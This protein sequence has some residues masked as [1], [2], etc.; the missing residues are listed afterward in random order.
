ML[1]SGFEGAELIVSFSFAELMG[2]DGL[3]ASPKS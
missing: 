3:I 2:T 1:L